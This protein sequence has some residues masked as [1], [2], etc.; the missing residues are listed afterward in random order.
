MLR[1]NAALRLGC[2][3]LLLLLVPGALSAGTAFKPAQNYRVG[4]GVTSAAVAD[5][6]GDGKPDLVVTS[7]AGGNDGHGVVTVLLGTGDGTFHRLTGFDSGAGFATSVAVADV[8]G[9]GKPDLVVANCASGIEPGNCPDEVSDGVVAV[10]LGN[11]NGTFQPPVT[12]DS[13]GGAS[14]SVAVA[15]VNLDGKLDVVVGNECEDQACTAPGGAGVLLGNGDGT[16]R[17]VVTYSGVG[18]GSVAV[19]DVNRDGNPDLVLGAPGGGVSVMLGNGDGTF[20]LL[21]SYKVGGVGSVAAVIADVNLDGKLDVVAVNSD[22]LVSVLLGNGDGTF[23]PAVI[24]R[25]GGDRSVSVAVADV[26]GDSEPDVVVASCALKVSMC[27]ATSEGAVSVLEGKGDGTLKRALTFDSGGLDADFVTVADVNGDSRPDLIV[28]NYFSSDVGVLLNDGPYVTST[29]L[30]SSLNPST[31][32]QSVTLTATVTS[33]GPAAPTGTV[34][35][36]NGA[37]SIGTST[38]SG[39]VATL[40]RRKLPAGTLSITATYNGD[41]QSGKSKS[42]PIIQVVSQATTT[43]TIASSLNPS[44]QGQAV[45]FTAKVTSPTV[46]VTGTVTFTAGATNLGTI[47]LSGGKASVTTSSLPAGSNTITAT[48]NGTAN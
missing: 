46:K 3:A 37:S 21:A 45:T 35:F 44:A 12:Y 5:L 13:G 28:T 23:Q 27:S 41:T 11:G 7:G 19:A 38:L 17:P 48:Y 34:T 47:T 16:F 15:D 24:Y 36:K 8:N 25:T 39:G 10:F 9:D 22:G 1:K 20:Q 4:G 14:V 42:P 6:N 32:G 18:Q 26:N 43:T 2:I 29:V 33:L 31:Y 40:T 30:T